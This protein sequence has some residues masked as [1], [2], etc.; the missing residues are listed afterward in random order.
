M[1]NFVLGKYL[2]YDS[3]IHKMDPRAKILAMLIILISIFVPAGYFGYL[4]LGVVIVAT[5][6]SAKLSLKFVWKSMKPM[7]FM[8]CFLLVI[9][10]LVFHNRPP[11]INDFYSYT[12]LF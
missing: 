6:L 3:V 12:L 2:P 7:M 1:G 9:N 8:L 10:I 11:H 5:V 4:A